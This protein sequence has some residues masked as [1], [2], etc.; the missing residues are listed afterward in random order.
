[1]N[2]TLR[3]W[4]LI[5]LCLRLVAVRALVDFPGVE[6]NAAVGQKAFASSYYNYT[7]NVLYDTVYTATNAVDGFTDESSWWS[8]GDDSNETVFWQ[9]NLTV[10]PPKLS[11]IIIR[12]HGFL[13]PLSYSVVVSY[14]GTRWTTIATVS[15]LSVSYDRVDVITS[16]MANVSTH[17]YYVRVIMDAANVCQD[18]FMCSGDATAATTE[19]NERRIYG[20]REFELWVKKT[21]SGAYTVA[22]CKVRL[23]LDSPLLLP[24]HL[25]SG[26]TGVWTFGRVGRRPSDSTY[27]GM[28]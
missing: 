28:A 27:G 19:T 9:V 2:Y 25:L 22:F 11:R 6:V 14:L 18:A 4:I 26:H 7:P 1:M 24:V 5:L 10:T 3:W 15:N 21:K 13:T 20:I 12:W 8:S 16:G 23:V 17:F